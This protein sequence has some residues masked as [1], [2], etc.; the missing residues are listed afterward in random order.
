MVAAIRTILLRKQSRLDQLAGAAQ[1]LSPIAIL[2]RG[3]AL[4]FDSGG[5]LLKNAAQVKT[6]DEISARLAKGVVTATVKKTS[7]QA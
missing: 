7:S 6:G 1:A 2:D 4:V 3:Y 5:K